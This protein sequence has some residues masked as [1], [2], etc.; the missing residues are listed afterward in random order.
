MKQSFDL[1]DLV[2]N[3]N[4]LQTVVDDESETSETTQQIEAHVHQILK[5]CM[6]LD[7]T[8]LRRNNIDEYKQ[9][10][11]REFPNFHG[12]YPTL[13]FSLIENPTTFPLYRLNEMLQIKKNME[14]KKIDKE[15]ASVALGQK[16][17]NEFVKDTV[18]ELDKKK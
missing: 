4:N 7:N 17:Y 1:R 9:K 18:S 15:T 2:Q 10:C 14:L 6:T 11:M 16:Y 5:Y 12:K 13:F 8:N 3:A